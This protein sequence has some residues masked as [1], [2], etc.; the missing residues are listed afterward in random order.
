MYGELGEEGQ[1]PRPN[2]RFY[3]GRR[4]TVHIDR[5]LGSA[6]PRYPDLRY[7]INYGYIPGTL[8]GDG[9]PIDAY[10]LGVD[11]PV[12]QAEGTVIAVVARTDDREDKLVVAPAGQRY[13]VKQIREAIFF[14]ERFFGGDII[15]M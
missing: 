14:Q 6:H 5:P 3:L 9:Q 4:V 13:S 11:E 2:L 15:A 12:E 1:V 7:P 8:S 10:L